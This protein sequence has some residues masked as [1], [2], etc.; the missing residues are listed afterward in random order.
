MN[1]CGCVAHL[2]VALGLGG[3]LEVGDCGRKHAQMSNGVVCGR[4][5][6][7]TLLL[8]EDRLRRLRRGRRPRR[9]RLLQAQVVQRGADVDHH[10]ALQRVLRVGVVEVVRRRQVL[11]GHGRVDGRRGH[12]A[13]LGLGLGLAEHVLGHHQGLLHLLLP[14]KFHTVFQ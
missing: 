10:R 4:W 5:R 9:A 12:A 7:L 11:L 14:Y 3:A 2:Q 13:V 1:G 6:L 8:L